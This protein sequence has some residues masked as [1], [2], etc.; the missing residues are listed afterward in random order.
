LAAGQCRDVNNVF[1]ITL[2]APV[3]I[4]LAR[5]GVNG[6]DTGVPAASTWYDVFVISDPILANPTAGLLT[7]QGNAPALPFN[8]S[9]YRRVGSIRLGVTTLIAPF[10]QAGTHQH[11]F[12]QW[13]GSI[14]VLSGGA[15]INWAAIDLSNA[16][17][18]RT[19]PIYMDVIWMADAVGVELDF[20]PGGS[21]QSTAISMN[22]NG[23]FVNT[24]PSIKIL[25]LVVANV[26]TIEYQFSG[27][28]QSLSIN[29]TG[30]DD[31]L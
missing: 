10:F 14:N 3:T 13:D 4:D 17:P 11:R 1:D 18:A 24:F 16:I 31:Y 22:S 8:Y 5:S 21:V 30:F 29:V 15:A 9:A 19:T 28:G 25:S 7:L 20:R 23:A 27:A 26:P 12:Y 6:L 2:N